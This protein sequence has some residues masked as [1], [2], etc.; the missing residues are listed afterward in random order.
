M[1]ELFGRMLETCRRNK[2]Q[3]P[4]AS[5]DPDIESFIWRGEAGASGW[6][7]WEPLE[8]T[9]PTDLS[10]LAPDLGPLHASI[11]SYFNAWWFCSLD[12]RIGSST[13]TLNPVAPG[14]EHE[15]FVSKVRRYRSARPG[16]DQ[17]P[18]GLENASSLQV[19][20][21]NHMGVVS[22][23][24]WERETLQEIAPSLEELLRRLE[25]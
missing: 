13:L 24:D 11:S 9:R 3:F 22:I 20:V 12:G 19:V 25:V 18:I 6:C 14:L 21:D 1:G 8:K 7:A 10:V 5:W 23:D 2:Q 15:S 16:V 4:V 17:I